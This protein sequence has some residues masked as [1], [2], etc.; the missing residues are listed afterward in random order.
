MNY[1][2]IAEK[3]SLMR[4][5]QN[6]YR[7]HKAE[8][9][10]KVGSIDFIALQGHI[11]GLYEPDE[12]DDWNGFKWEEI[13]YPMIPDV[14]KI[15][16]IDRTYNR[17]ILNTIKSQVKNYDGIIVGTD[18]DVEGFGIYYLLEHFLHIEK[19]KALRFMESS[20]TDAEI[21]KSLL[22]M[23]DFHT[24]PAHIN[25]TQSYLLRA[26]ADWLFGMNATRM[27]SLKQNDTMTIG[28]VKSPTIKL[29][30]D[31]S[32]A[33]ESFNVKTYYNLVADYGDFTSVLVNEK[34]IPVVFDNKNNLSTIS[35][36][37]VV[38]QK[39]TE[40][41]YTH[42]PK[43]YHLTAI[44]AEAEQTL[45]LN[46]ET[47]LDII[48]SLYEK[49]KVIS[50]PRTQCRY[51]SYE[52]SKEFPRMLANMTVFE[53]LKPF[54]E[55]ITS[56][57]IKRVMGDKRVV[58]NKEVEKEAHDALLPTTKKPNFDEMTK[59]E[60]NV[61]FMIY[62]RLLSQFLP[63]LAEDKTN[64]LIL[65]D[66]KY[67][68]A[69]GKTVV[70]QGWRILYGQAKENYIPML[71]EGDTVNAKSIN[72]KE[73]KTSPPKR[74]TRGTLGTAMENI[75]NQIED[76]DLKKSLAESKGIGTTATRT[77]I[78]SDIIE[79]GFVADKK[80]RIIYN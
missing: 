54:V 2:F 23:R 26:R 69:K 65:H 53:S 30:Y 72:F 77:K 25:F 33:I 13:D 55:K 35:L 20:L 6:C 44:Q 47:T 10:Q 31:N 50:Y 15:K 9:Q 60:I 52:K 36:Q 56:D 42:A 68:V 28:R 58:N 17:K 75:A 40:R 59:D 71:N 66:D 22:E 57:D 34:G 29:V 61:C 80:K 37:G 5:V 45:G 4:D 79:R 8:I 46:T 24:D 43:L 32:M 39:K 16:P 62:K 64:L 74:L 27:M 18:P 11:C 70:N 73:R 49:H 14:W 21:L 63:D 76:K 78:I 3:P 51:V 12:Y 1:L 19:M 7:N 48:Q 67:F 38:K 41:V